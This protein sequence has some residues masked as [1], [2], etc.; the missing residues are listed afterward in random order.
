M[1]WSL[2]VPGSISNTAPS[3]ALGFKSDFVVYF[4]E[5][6]ND[7][8]L[9]VMSLFSEPVYENGI[10]NVPFIAKMLVVGMF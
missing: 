2:S 9:S 5:I 8:G 4:C 6:F 1:E 3:Y 7:T 10:I